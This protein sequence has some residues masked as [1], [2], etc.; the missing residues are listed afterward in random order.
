MVNSS[1]SLEAMIQQMNYTLLLSKIVLI[2]HCEYNKAILTKIQMATF[3]KTEPHLQ[4][5]DV[6]NTKREQDW[7]D[8][9]LEVAGNGVSWILQ[10]R[11]RDFRF[12][13]YCYTCNNY[14]SLCGMDIFAL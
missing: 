8:L 3:N 1:V 7:N 13:V 14:C 4:H 6:R 12:C 11:P 10:A 5:E 2:T 9:E